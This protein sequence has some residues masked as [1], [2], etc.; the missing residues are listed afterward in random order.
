[1]AN[2]RVAH[3]D[4]T[5][6]HLDQACTIAG[7]ERPELLPLDLQVKLRLRSDV[8]GASDRPL[9]GPVGTAIGIPE[10]EIHPCLYLSTADG[11]SPAH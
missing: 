3:E 8:I 2:Q 4:E 10:Q 6:L 1:M 5:Y 9:A 11:F 7:P